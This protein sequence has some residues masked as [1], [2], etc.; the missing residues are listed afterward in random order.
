MG[1]LSGMFGKAT[2]DARSARDLLDEGAMLLDV[3]EPGEWQAGHAPDARHIPLGKLGQ[4]TSSLPADRRIVVVC[5]SGNRSS[6]AVRHLRSQ[7]FDALN[8][9]GGMRA[10]SAAGLP[11]NANGGGQGRIV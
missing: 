3:R 5:R 6:Q 1:F 2:V 11:V 10:W 7:G 9:R 8:L 4:K